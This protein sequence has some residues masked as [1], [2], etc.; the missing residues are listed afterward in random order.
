[1][2]ITLKSIKHSAFAS[3]ETHCFEATVYVDGKRAFKVSNQGHGGCDLHSPVTGQTHSE[4][5]SMVDE[6]NAELGKEMV[7]DDDWEVANDLNI[8]VSDLVNQWLA[9]KEIKKVLKKVAYIKDN[10][11]YVMKARFK[12]NAQTLEL[13]KK[14]SWWTPEHKLLN[15]LP[16]EEIRQYFS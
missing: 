16:I 3:Q 10:E 9:D 5:N 12:P 11:L 6:I 13:V 15:G 14:A 2:N 8:V 7:G 1:M 4:V